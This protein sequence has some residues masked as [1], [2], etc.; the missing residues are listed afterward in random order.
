[1]KNKTKRVSLTHGT[2]T[3]DE[4][5]SSE[6]IEALNKL[7]EVA[8]N[9]LADN[10]YQGCNTQLHPDSQKLLSECFNDLEVK[11]IA[12]QDKY[13]YSNEWLIHDW[14]DECRQEMIKHILKGD[15]KDVAIYALFMM[16]RGWS[17]KPNKPLSLNS[18]WIKIDSEADLPKETGTFFFVSKQSGNVIVDYFTHDSRMPNYKAIEVFRYS[19]WQPIDKPQLPI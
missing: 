3:V 15:P 11:M 1:M 13:G 6:T 7:S 18:K 2:A 16:F 19:H 9:G 17:T 4:N 14:E 8:F 10:N 12:N 5:C